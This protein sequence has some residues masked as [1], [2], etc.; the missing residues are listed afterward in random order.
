MEGL[1]STEYRCGIPSRNKWS[2]AGINFEDDSY[3]WVLPENDRARDTLNGTRAGPR[4]LN[5]RTENFILRASRENIPPK[6]G[7]SEGIGRFRER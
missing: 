1:T 7:V 5:G 2:R 6:S 3:T 4:V